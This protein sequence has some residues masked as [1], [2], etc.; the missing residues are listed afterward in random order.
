MTDKGTCIFLCSKTNIMAL[1]WAD[2]GFDCWIVDI[3]HP[4]GWSTTN[5]PLIRSL[6]IDV[7]RLDVVGIPGNF[8][9]GFAFPPCTHLAVSGARWFK[10]KGFSSLEEALSIVGACERILKNTGARRGRGYSFIRA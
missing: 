8:V 2:A 9:F 5:H 4:A 10:E 7:R 3:Q 1:P 6:G